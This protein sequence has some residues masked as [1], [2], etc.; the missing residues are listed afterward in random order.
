MFGAREPCKTISRAVD[1]MAGS[2]SYE[3]GA[4]ALLSVQ[5]HLRA[6]WADK[7]VILVAPHFDRHYVRLLQQLGQAG[8]RLLGVV[9]RETTAA[10]DADVAGSCR[11][12][13]FQ[14]SDAP[15]GV[16][17]EDFLRAPGPALLHWLGSVDPAS[18]AVVMASQFLATPTVGGRKVHGWR[19][20]GWADWENKTV[21]HDKLTDLGVSLPRGCVVAMGASG[22][23]LEAD[24]DRIGLRGACVAAFEPASAD[25]GSAATLRYFA[26]AQDLAAWTPP[27]HSARVRLTE[28]VAGLPASI[29]SLVAGDTVHSFDPI[30]IVAL[31]LPAE[32]RF[33]F[34]G[35]STLWRPSDALRKTMRETAR[36]IGMAMA[37][38][39]GYE[40]EFSVD[41][42]V[43]DDRFFVTEV[44]ARH[45]SGLGLRA[46]WPE[47]PI[48]LLSR[49]IAEPGSVPNSVPLEAV[50][51]AA[52]DAIRSAPS[53]SVRFPVDPARVDK[54]SPWRLAGCE[55][56]FELAPNR[57]RARLLS[58]DPVPR[59]SIIGP[60]VAVLS[61]EL[62]S[63]AALHSLETPRR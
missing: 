56:K 62:G 38:A 13:I 5:R 47:F 7:D 57:T 30:E 14:V 55:A 10:K 50:V 46:A 35:T 17:F 31:T 1:D 21:S 3:A 41:G 34:C 2:R 61:R 59:S 53:W 23:R 40:G 20:A 42:I 54:A 18:R 33:V 60:T 48:E 39:D 16:E 15:S 51:A 24:A 29:L 36:L 19:R 52:R 28:Y 37:H 8:A 4:G 26:D 63:G 25:R 32:H 9:C 49:S 11:C 43:E 44:N 6:L 12:P 58:L 45:A 27:D 22:G